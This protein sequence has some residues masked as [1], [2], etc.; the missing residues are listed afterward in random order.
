MFKL[1]Q[2]ITDNLLDNV[3]DLALDAG[4][5]VMEIYC[6]NEFKEQFK[7]DNSPLTEADIASHNTIL[8]G[9]KQLT[10]DIPILSEESVE[11]DYEERKNWQLFWLIDPLDGTKEF[12]KRN[13]EFTINIAL[14]FNGAPI[15]GVV[16]APVLGLSY[17][18]MQAGG[19]FIQRQE[20]TRIEIKVAERIEHDKLEIVGSRSH[21]CERFN[22][23]L[24]HLGECDYQSMGSSL[25][26][27]LIADGSAH[28]YPRLGPTMEWDTAA[29]QCI[30]TE[31]GGM[32]CDEHGQQLLYN[33]PNLLN[34]S[35][36][37]LSATDGFLLKKIMAYKW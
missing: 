5:K 16:H 8:I 31:A 29:A 35:F 23:L 11:I 19:A 33:K 20:E 6:T 18:A 2:I 24:S 37:V 32:V 21:S 34:A 28:L 9:L 3:L 13:G 10:P 15:L 36:V 30:V 22:N 1:P 17:F 27:C 26:F 14:I 12:I 7:Q 4:K 25:K